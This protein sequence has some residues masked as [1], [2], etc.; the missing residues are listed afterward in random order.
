[1][2]DL[3]TLWWQRRV[4]LT[5]SHMTTESAHCIVA[6]VDML[7]TSL[8]CYFVY[9]LCNCIQT[10]HISH[11]AFSISDWLHSSW[12]ARLISDGFLLLISNFACENR[13]IPVFLHEPLDAFWPPCLGNCTQ[14][15]QS[16]CSPSP[17]PRDYAIWHLL[18]PFFWTFQSRQRRTELLSGGAAGQGPCDLVWGCTGS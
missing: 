12:L 5:S 15:Q 2:R 17:G 13:S 11:I 1:M 9:C 6:I 3:N 16:V 14:R 4:N 18:T 10:H 8:Y 7:S